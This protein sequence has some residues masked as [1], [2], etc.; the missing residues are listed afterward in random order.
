MRTLLLTLCGLLLPLPALAHVSYVIDEQARGGSMGSDW[1][2]FFSPLTQIHNIFLILATLLVVVALPLFIRK[3]RLAHTYFAHIRERLAGYKQYVPWIVRLSLG[4]ALIGAGSAGA[5]ISPTL[6][7]MPAYSFIQIAIGFCILS[8]FLLVPAVILTIALYA[9]AV[10]INPYLIGNIEIAILALAVLIYGDSRPG[11]DHIVGIPFG[12]KLSQLQ[13]YIPLLLRIGIGGAMVYLAIFEKF[14]NPHMSE[15]VIS[16]FSL[17][18]V[19]PVS[20]AMW[21]MGAGA[22][23]LLVGLLLILGKWT[24][25][26]AVVTIVILTLTFFY[27]GE[28]VY[29]HV[30]LFGT[31]SA[32]IILG[33]GKLSLDNRRTE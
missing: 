4:I 29:S 20:E 13:E 6:S 15:M 33:G 2:F 27:F 11:I 21:V 7:D 8:G 22:V 32:L 25:T 12:L 24:R 26:S 1:A 18:S 16:N 5:L 17:T 23:E 3:S 9:M 28:D 14:L 30:T 31:L 19:V 10:F